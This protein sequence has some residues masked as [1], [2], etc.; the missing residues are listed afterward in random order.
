MNKLKKEDFIL[1]SNKL[2]NNKYDY[3]QVDYKNT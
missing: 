3:S 1:K 2:F